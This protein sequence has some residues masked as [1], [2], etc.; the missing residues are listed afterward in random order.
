M[1]IDCLGKFGYSF[2]LVDESA[3]KLTQISKFN[4]K[5]LSIEGINCLVTV[6]SIDKFEINNY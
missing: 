6:K 2:F 5:Y 3:K 4:E 1:C